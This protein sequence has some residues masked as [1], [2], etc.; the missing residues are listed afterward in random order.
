MHSVAANIFNTCYIQEPHTLH[1]PEDMLT[2]L[3]MFHEAA[4]LISAG[5][6]PSRRSPLSADIASR[7]PESVDMS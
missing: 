1:I 7:I 5:S 4:A 2:L 6:P 3:L